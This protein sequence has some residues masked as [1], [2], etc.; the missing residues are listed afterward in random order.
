MGTKT[1]PPITSAT[2]FTDIIVEITA[3][4]SAEL[5]THI[6]VKVNTV[7]VKIP[8]APA[9]ERG[10][11][12]RRNL[13]FAFFVSQDTKRYTKYA[14]TPIKTRGKIE[15]KGFINTTNPMINERTNEH[16]PNIVPPTNIV[17]LSPKRLI[18]TASGKVRIAGVNCLNKKLNAYVSVKR[19]TNISAE[20]TP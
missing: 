13:L 11:I 19:K 17:F 18:P 2:K 10:S 5:K 9:K 14:T 15:T 3:A 4:N 16:A 8:N 12:S 20:S 6:I 7:F 1:I